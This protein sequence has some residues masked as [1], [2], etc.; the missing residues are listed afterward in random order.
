MSRYCIH[1]AAAEQEWR[2]LAASVDESDHPPVGWSFRARIKESEHELQPAPTRM[3]RGID[4]HAKPMCRYVV[5]R[6]GKIVLHRCLKT[7]LHDRLRDIKPFRERG[8]IVG[9]ETA[10]NWYWLAN[11]AR[12]KRCPLYSATR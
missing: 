6:D 5:A 2:R 1:T 8:L 4:L 9:L 11:S 10:Y 12:L 3:L 7:Q